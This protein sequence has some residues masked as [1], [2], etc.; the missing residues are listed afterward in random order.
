M[1]LTLFGASGRTGRHLLEQA[2]AAGHTVQALV[3]DPNKLTTTNEHLTV[4]QGNVQ[5]ADAVQRVIAGSQAVLSVL[6]PP[7][8]R[9]DHQITTGMKHILAAMERHGVQRLIVTVGAGVRDPQ[10][11]PGLLDKLIGA[12]VKLFSR[13]V[14]Q[15]MLQVD[16]LVR[17]SDCD[18]TIVRVPMLTDGAQNGEVRVG[19]I[20]QGTGPR[21]ARADLAAF[22]LEQLSDERYLHQAPVISN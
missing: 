6:G 13:H 5:D 19:Y 12:A 14:Y 22:M 3:R 11:Q 21:L 17:Q 2:L 7:S 10:D 18:W 1:Q 15:D 9:P 8:N 16:R 20:G 4:M